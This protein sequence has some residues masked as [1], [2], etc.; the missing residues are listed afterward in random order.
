[1]RAGE[2]ARSDVFVTSKLWNDDHRPEHVEAACRRTLG[3]LQLDYL[4]LY[5]VHWPM[6]WRKGTVMVPDDVPAVATWR[7]MEALVDA[8]L[9]RHIGVSNF[10]ETRLRDLL[11]HATKPVYCNQVEM[12]PFLQQPSL[13]EFCQSRGIRVVAW[14]PLAKFSAIERCSELQA[15]ARAKG[16]SVTQVVLRWH[17]QRAVHAIPRSGNAEHIAANARLGDFALD[18]SE[19]A[20]MASLDRR[21]RIVP[22]F[23]GVFADTSVFPWRLI[24]TALTWLARVVFACFRFDMKARF[25]GDC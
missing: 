17:L 9:V 4:D 11:P 8:G 21:E 10:D 7:A 16:R 24:A 13:V 23:A 5:L 22:D 19:M 12:H 18:A 6:A 14:S 15:L 3:D 2:I 1:M 25:Y 20:R